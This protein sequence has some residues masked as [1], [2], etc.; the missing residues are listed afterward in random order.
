MLLGSSETRPFSEVTVDV[1]RKCFIGRRT[2]RT[3]QRLQSVPN[4]LE[5][6]HKIIL[7]ACVIRATQ[8]AA[9]TLRVPP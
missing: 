1:A 3:R 6:F 9:Y 2:S 5:S 8:R 4:Q 7:T